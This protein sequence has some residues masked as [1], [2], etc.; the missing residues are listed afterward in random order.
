[1]HGDE[2]L[3]TKVLKSDINTNTFTKYIQYVKKTQK[4][5]EA[6]K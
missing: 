1:M 6:H 4:K 5:N 2:K 3:F